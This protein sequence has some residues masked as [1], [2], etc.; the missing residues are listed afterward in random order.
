MAFAVSAELCP[1]RFLPETSAPSAPLGMERSVQA[2]FVS[3]EVHEDRRETG[4][5]TAVLLRGH[6]ARRQT[7]RDSGDHVLLLAQVQV[8][9][10]WQYHAQGDTDEARLSWHRRAGNTQGLFAQKHIWQVSSALKT[11]AIANSFTFQGESEV[12]WATLPLCSGTS[13]F[14]GVP[15]KTARKTRQHS[16]QWCWEDCST[17]ALLWALLPYE[18]GERTSGIQRVHVGCLQ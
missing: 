15:C 6:S 13:P 10:P 14:E 8:W 4:E 12:S 7:H 3:L 11:R 9:P 18:P 5:K 1:C 17:T 16:S 2:Q